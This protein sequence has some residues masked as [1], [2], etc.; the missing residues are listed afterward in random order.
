MAGS[1]DSRA[2]GIKLVL[3]QILILNLLVSAAKAAW[4]LVSGSTAM[5]ADGIHSLT[6]GAGNV[7]APHRDGGSG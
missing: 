3:W 1:V 2:H 7:V 5:V 6:D 4:G